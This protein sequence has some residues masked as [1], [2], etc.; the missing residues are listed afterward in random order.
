MPQKPPD[1]TAAYALDGPEANRRLYAD[2]ADSYDETFAGAEGYRLPEAVAAR[3]AE[4]GGQGPVLD[5]GA[6]TGLVAER[7][8]G[9]G[10]GP[11]DGLDLSEEMLTVARAKGCY[12]TCLVGDVLDPAAMPD[13]AYDGAV[14]AGTFTLGHVGPEGIDTVLTAVRPGGRVVLSINEA[15]YEARGFDKAL[16]ALAPR[17]TDLASQSTRIYTDAA[18]PAHRQDMARLVSFRRR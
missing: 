4:L 15:H 13:S 18:D 16:T 17:L 10:I 6:G 5:I 9:R 3:F 1:L 7:L 12:R 8:A 14:S 2:W 11:I